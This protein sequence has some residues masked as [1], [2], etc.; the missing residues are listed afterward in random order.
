RHLSLQTE[1]I[2][3]VRKF[4][5]EFL[6]QKNDAYCLIFQDVLERIVELPSLM[7]DDSIHAR[8]THPCVR[9]DIIT[10][11]K[12]LHGLKLPKDHEGDDKPVQAHTFCKSYENERLTKH[13]GVLTD[14]S[15][16]CTCRARHG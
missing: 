16:R 11:Q 9:V 10:D 5:S 2:D 14:G 13:T 12:H 3:D 8:Q 6:C 1:F 4:P 15:K 7:Y